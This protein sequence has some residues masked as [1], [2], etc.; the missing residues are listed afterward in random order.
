L[1]QGVLGR[2]LLEGRGA[3]GLEAAVMVAPAVEGVLAEAEVLADLPQS[4]EEA[5]AF[6]TAG[7]TTCSAGLVLALRSG[8]PLEE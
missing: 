4:A 5:Q 8:E 3:I 7:A 1:R 2:W 6:P